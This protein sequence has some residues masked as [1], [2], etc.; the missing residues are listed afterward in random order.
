MLSVTIGE[1]ASLGHDSWVPV[2]KNSLSA[3]ADKVTYMKR[4][5]ESRPQ[6]DRSNMYWIA[7]LN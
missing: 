7:F 6:N 2:A 5:P 4:S 1:I 3:H